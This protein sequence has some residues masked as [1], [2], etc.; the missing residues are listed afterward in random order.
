MGPGSHRIPDTLLAHP[1]LLTQP[2][3]DQPSGPPMEH[4]GLILVRPSAENPTSQRKVTQEYR[5]LQAIEDCRFNFQSWQ[6][7]DI[8]GDELIFEETSAHEP[9]PHL[10]LRVDVLSNMWFIEYEEMMFNLLDRIEKIK[11]GDYQQCDIAKQNVFSCVED[12]LDRLRGLKLSAWKRQAES[13]ASVFPAP[14]SGAFR[15]IDTGE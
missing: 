10:P 7:A 1:S 8:S 12:E 14:R 15:E 13:T 11:T 6:R 4:Q 2:E 9:P 3:P 5:I